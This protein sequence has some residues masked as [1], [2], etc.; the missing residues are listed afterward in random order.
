MSAGVSIEDDPDNPVGGHARVTFRGV[1]PPAARATLLIEALTEGFDYRGPQRVESAVSPVDGG[2]A[3]RI[4]PDVVGA[5][6]Q[7]LAVNLAI[8]GTGKGFDV[9]WP[10]LTPPRAEPRRS[11]LST[12][13]KRRVL[14][15][16]G[17]PGLRPQQTPVQVTPPVLPRTPVVEEQLPHTPEKDEPRDA[18]VT[19]PLAEPVDAKTST[20]PTVLEAP[21]EDAKVADKQAKRAKS[22]GWSLPR[23][24]AVGAVA[25]GAGAGSIALMAWPKPT[26]LPTIE[27]KGD[28]ALPSP[29]A[30]LADLPTRSPEGEDVKASDS[31]RFRERGERAGSVA[32][33][34]FW[35]RWAMRSLL[36]SRANNAAA[37]L[38][39][40]AT[41]L[42]T[43]PKADGNV[44]V[45][46]F[47]WEL[48]AIGNDCAAMDN[49]A[50]ALSLPGSPD[51]S[52][53]IATWQKRAESCR[54]HA[55]ST[56]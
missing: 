30:M 39:D 41:T 45:A 51:A 49:I 4:G 8:E 26:P 14:A 19:V 3:L 10:E 36:D 7:G 25:F 52:D 38:D 43:S 24:A 34:Q 5:L 22:A 55:T 53:A 23:V 27:A 6:K 11:A 44:A 31:A 47:I 46:R 1:T 15:E 40:F 2:I 18:A 56:R 17:N 35:R 32:E 13:K 12:G 28:L 50:A 16:E 42:A 21:V 33:T 9:L 20:P 37:V 54:R 48:A 29:Y